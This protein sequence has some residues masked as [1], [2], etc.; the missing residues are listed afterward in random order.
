MIEPE[1]FDRLY[2]V[3]KPVMN[4]QVGSSGKIVFH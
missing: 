3:C 1:V 4:K 2:A